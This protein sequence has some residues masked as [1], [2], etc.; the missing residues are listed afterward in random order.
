MTFNQFV[1]EGRQDS[2]YRGPLLLPSPS[3]VSPPPGKGTRH[4]TDYAH[5]PPSAEPATMQPLTAP[6]SSA[7]LAGS[8]GAMPLDLKGSDGR[9]DV[10]LQPGSLDLSHATVPGGSSPAGPL[11]VHL[12]QVFGH[13]VSLTNV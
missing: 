8:P 4:V 6:L 11:S 9:L 5:L 10:R 2:T 1:K 3:Q 12:T 7:F 13:Y